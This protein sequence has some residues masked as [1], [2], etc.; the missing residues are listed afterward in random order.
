MQLDRAE[1]EAYAFKHV[2]TQEAAYESMPFALRARLHVRV[3][4][5]LE[6]T[7]PDAIDRN[8]DLL[9]HHFWHGDDEERKRGYL[10]RAGEAAQAAYAN[11]AAIDYLERLEPLLEGADRAQAL[12]RLS[13]VLALVGGWD[14]A[15]EVA[16]EVARA[17][18][19]RGGRRGAGLGRDRAR[20]DRPQARPLRGRERAP[21]ARDRA[22]RRR[23]PRTTVRGACCT[24][25]ARS[26]PSAGRSTRPAR[27][28]RR[29]W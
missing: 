20:R 23:R 17:R 21:G 19:R 1:D 16:T 15:E 8:L 27:T 6:E 14:R 25:R 7:Q 5:F 26:P 22:L 12:L 9:A 11:E 13:D 29:V 18:G 10:R 28:T 24:W 2:V 3:G 4:T